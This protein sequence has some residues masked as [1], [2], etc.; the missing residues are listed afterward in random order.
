MELVAVVDSE[1]AALEAAHRES[2]RAWPTL[3]DGLQGGHFDGVIIASP[4]HEHPDQT[5]ACLRAGLAVLVEKPFAL[6]LEAAARVAQESTGLGIPVTVGQNFRFLRRERAVRKALELDVG[7]VVGAS[8]VSARAAT[9]AMPHLASIRHGPVWDICVHH[10]DA[11]RVRFGSAPQQVAMSVTRLGESSDASRLRFELALI[12]RDG[13]AVLYQHSEGAPGYHHSEWIEGERR[14][15]LVDDQEVAVLF[16]SHRPRSVRV[17]RGPDP[18]QA[19]LDEFLDSL[20]SGDSP[21]LGPQDNLL[22]VAM[23]EAAVRSE[24][25][26]RPVMLDEVGEA[27]GVPL[28]AQTVAHG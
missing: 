12:W 24:R 26:G 25:L 2:L 8:I 9:V 11:L 19:V 21:R 22:T 17:A 18:E 13:P 15:I 23:L 5:I 3:A 6:T 1:P 7:R 14:A 27:A 20:D 28:G 16:P 10:L 4:P